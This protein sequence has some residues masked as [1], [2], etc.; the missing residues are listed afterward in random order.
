MLY[1]MFG[2][3]IVSFI[4]C[5]FN[6]VFDVTKTSLKLVRLLKL[7]TCIGVPLILIFSLY[8]C[9]VPFTTIV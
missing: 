7:R 5:I 2:D 3:E 4:V 9:D 1:V 6:V 8:I